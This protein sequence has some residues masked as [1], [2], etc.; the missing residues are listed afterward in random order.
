MDKNL[1]NSYLCLNFQ[2]SSANLDFICDLEKLRERIR[3]QKILLEDT[4][5]KRLR[6]EWLL[7]DQLEKVIPIR[8]ILEKT[9]LLQDPFDK[10]ILNDLRMKIQLLEDSL[11]W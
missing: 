4:I 10:I 1:K 11:E 2:T 6:E 8:W 7:E 5:P 9:Q 3:S